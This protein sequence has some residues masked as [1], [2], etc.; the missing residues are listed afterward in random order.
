MNN[1][2]IFNLSSKYENLIVKIAFLNIFFIWGATFLAVIYGLQGFPPFILTG[3]RFTI[4]GVILLLFASYKGEK[5][6]NLNNWLRNSLPALFVLTGGTGLVAWCEQYVSSTEAAIV[7]ATG[8]FWFILFDKRN[9]SYYKSNKFI[10]LGLIL[11]FF[12]LIVFLRDSLSGTSSVHPNVSEFE[13]YIA[14]GSMA[15]SSILWVIG[16]LFSKNKPSSHSTILNIAQQLLLAGVMNFIISGLKG[17]WE[18]FQITQAPLSAWFG[19]SFL[20]VFGSIIAYL[21]YIWLMSVSTP[22]KVSVHT[23][24][25][26]IVAVLLG[27]V[28]SG[29]GISFSQIIGL[30]IILF[31]VLLTSF[32]SYKEI[33]N[34]FIFRY[35]SKILRLKYYRL[36]R[37]LVHR[38]VWKSLPSYYGVR[39]IYKV[40]NPGRYQI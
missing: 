28:I 21:S 13:R 30:F 32:S 10:V 37:Y 18:H 20:I 5:P 7:G 22:A 16:S 24:I 40:L 15:I 3:I 9:W 1:L 38:Y 14:F 19:L 31:G 4:A 29:E 11:G 25:N 2:N 17:E 33:F 34:K 8:P 36:S 27:W 6:N 35:Y 23:Y 12:G 26:P 39:Y